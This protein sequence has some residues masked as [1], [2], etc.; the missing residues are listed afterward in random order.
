MDPSWFKNGDFRYHILN[1]NNIPITIEFINNIFK[2]YNFKHRVKNLANFQL[3]MV[4]VTYLDKEFISEK[5]AKM[6]KDI[7]PISD[8]DYPDAFPLQPAS[9]GRLEYLGDAVIHHAIADYL[10]ERY[11]NREEGFMTKLRTKLEKAETLSYL[12]KQLELH[13]YA[14]IARNIE[15]VN[16]RIYNIHL[17]EDI[18]EAFIGA[19]SLETTYEK[20]KEFI[21]S[22]FEAEIDIAE[23]IYHNDN[24]KDQLM[25]YF[26]KLKDPRYKEPRYYEDVSQQKIVKNGFNEY[27]LFTSVVK[28]GDEIIGVGVGNSK[29]KAEQNA[30]YNALVKLGVIETNSND[31]NDYYGVSENENESENNDDDYY[32]F[33]D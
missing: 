28:K 18:F 20:C 21:V 13:K 2:R 12:A 16:G 30:A 8:E 10:Y 23:L 5:T 31:E 9:Y 15:K 24:Y 3:A 29:S 17:T 22:V 4:H 11:E 26:H 25:Q 32:D 27:K 33:S 7:E 19:L 1:E 14:I 6:L